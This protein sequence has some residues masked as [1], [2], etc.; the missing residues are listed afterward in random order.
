MKLE[1]H[2][3]SSEG[4]EWTFWRLTDSHPFCH[5][6]FR[7]GKY[8]DRVNHSSKARRGGMNEG[9]NTDILYK[10]SREVT[11]WW[12]LY[13]RDDSVLER[14][15]SNVRTSVWIEG[16]VLWLSNE[17]CG[18]FA[19]SGSFLPLKCIKSKAKLTVGKPHL[20]PDLW[21]MLYW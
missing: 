2:K 9:K 19:V 17:L 7:G 8:L 15:T 1:P 20:S 13:P 3:C 4:L 11:N 21:R 18:Y 14:V 16:M 5:A 6:W 10:S 12:G